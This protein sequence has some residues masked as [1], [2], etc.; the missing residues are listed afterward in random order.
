MHPGASRLPD[1]SGPLRRDSR[2]HLTALLRHL[3]RCD[4]HR[5]R[6]TCRLGSAECGRWIPTERGRPR[7][8]RPLPRAAPRRSDAPGQGS[9]VFSAANGPTSDRPCRNPMVNCALRIPR[10]DR[11][12]DFMSVL[13]TWKRIKA[14]ILGGIGIN[15]LVTCPAE[16]V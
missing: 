3:S 5:I 13:T 9:P 14:T 1:P 8:K 7:R 6:L 12:N 2:A 16:P 10:S 4:L 15:K 11:F